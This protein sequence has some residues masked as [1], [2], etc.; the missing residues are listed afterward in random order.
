MLFDQR[1]VIFVKKSAT[2][3]C[4]SMNFIKDKGGGQATWIIIADAQFGTT[5]AVF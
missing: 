5:I 1:N 4:T 2:K 3:M